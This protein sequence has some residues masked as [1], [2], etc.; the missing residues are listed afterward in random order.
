[1]LIGYVRVSKAGGSQTL[2]GAEVP[3]LVR[4]LGLKTDHGRLAIHPLMLV[5]QARKWRLIV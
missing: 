2:A 5:A 1:M 3:Q 4:V